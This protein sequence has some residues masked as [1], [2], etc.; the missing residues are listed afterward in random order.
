MTTMQFTDYNGSTN[1]LSWMDEGVCK[2][3]DPELFFADEGWGMTENARFL[4]STCPVMD[5]CREYAIRQA[6]LEGVWGG[7]TH[8]ERVALRRVKLTPFELALI[9]AEEA[10]D[11]EQLPQTDEL[12]LVAA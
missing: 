10:E 6:G 11:E 8:S 12:E 9:E 7:L 4:C 3:T 5:T 1:P 2:E